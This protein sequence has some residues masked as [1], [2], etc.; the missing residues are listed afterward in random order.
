[1]THD[2]KINYMRHAVGICGYGFQ[3]KDLDLMVSLYEL[4]VQKAGDTS[5]MDTTKVESEV[6][7]R[8]DARRK[9]ELL[10]K[11]STKVK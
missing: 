8:D 7:G 1:M 6:K 9:S 3:T 2:Q 4:I 10:D 11:I 5:L